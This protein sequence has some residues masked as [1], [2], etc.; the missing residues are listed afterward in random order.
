MEPSPHKRL[1]DDIALR[2]EVFLKHPDRWK[3]LYDSAVSHLDELAGQYTSSVQ[4]QSVTPAVA[5]AAARDVCAG[6]CSRAIARLDR[7]GIMDPNRADARATLPEV[8]PRSPPDQDPTSWMVLRRR[9]QQGLRPLSPV[10][11]C[12]LT[13]ASPG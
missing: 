3:E 13:R 8:F 10:P 4:P 1:N 7:G 12:R 11:G 5:A 9:S 6:N 2:M